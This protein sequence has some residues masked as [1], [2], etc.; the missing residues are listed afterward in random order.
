MSKKV[1]FRLFNKNNND[2]KKNSK[3]IGGDL[4]VYSKEG[5]EGEFCELMKKGYEEMAQINLE[6]SSSICLSKDLNKY[7][8]DDINEYE[9]W[10]FGV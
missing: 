6:L 2:Y 9:K 1:E 8:F 7:N 3:Y 5:Y 10:L 4:I